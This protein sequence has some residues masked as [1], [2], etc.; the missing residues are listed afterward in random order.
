MDENE[1]D[2]EIIRER[3]LGRIPHPRELQPEFTERWD[4]P[5][6]KYIVGQMVSY[7]VSSYVFTPSSPQTAIGGRKDSKGIVIGFCADFGYLVLDKNI[8]TA[9]FMGVG[10]M[11]NVDDFEEDRLSPITHNFTD[12]GLD[13]K[14]HFILSKPKFKIGQ[15]V[16]HQGEDYKIMGYVYNN[17]EISKLVDDDSGWFYRLSFPDESD[18]SH[19]ES[20]DN[21]HCDWRIDIEEPNETVLKDYGEA[22]EYLSTQ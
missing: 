10:F 5:K 14:H 16:W 15:I 7:D 9:D 2:L 18:I 1:M 22:V 6:P 11:L 12:D 8:I 19:L 21:L 4:K 3:E 20:E 13:V 17:P